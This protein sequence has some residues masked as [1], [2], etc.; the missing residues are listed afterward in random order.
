[1]L[2]RKCQIILLILLTFG[3]VTISAAQDT[4]RLSLNDALKMAQENNLNIKNSQLDLKIAQKKIWETIAIGLPHVDGTAKYTFNPKVPTLPATAFDPNAK[5]GDVIELG[6]KQNIVYDLTVS[7]LI[8]NGAYL[9]G[10][11]A[12]RAYYDMSA[13]SLEKSQLD[14]SESVTNTYFMVL[15]G[16]ESRKILK[17]NLENVNK[18]FEEI[19]ETY[20]QGFVEKTDVD[21]LE[22]TANTIS[23]AIAQINNNL[24]MAGRLLKIHLGLAESAN[25]V[26]TDQL[27]MEEAQVNK[28]TD[29]A[30][31][32]FMLEK[33]VDFK[34][35]TTAELLAKYDYKREMSNS[36]PVIAAY[37]NH[38]EKWKK[39]AFDFAPKDMI[40]INL[41]LPIF[42]SGQRSALVAQKRMAFEKATNNK[43]Y[44]SNTLLM[45]STQFQNDL[46]TKLEKFQIQK[47][48]KELSDVIYQRTL[49]KYK[50]GVSSSLE[51]MTIQNQYLN[52]LTDYYQGIYDVVGAKTKLEKLFNINQNISK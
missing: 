34:M 23:N 38:Q 18:T 13:E 37:Y 33:S 27:G 42:S 10:L 43:L 17:A 6:V 28:L 3:G 29:L 52:S 46:R 51:L 16:E 50:L 30:K 1:M 12:S 19:K 47:K 24:E 20:K 25:I 7:Q 41:S 14:I 5:P 8:F 11:K 32:P 4:L 40:G 2:S 36:L 15:V 45:Q 39:P 22:L 35:L 9:V 31:E 21:Q 48:S 44:V 26:L 49:E